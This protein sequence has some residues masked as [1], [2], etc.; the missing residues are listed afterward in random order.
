MGIY[1]RQSSWG[2]AVLQCPES[3]YINSLISL[4]F[5]CCK[6]TPLR[7]IDGSHESY[8]NYSC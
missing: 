5:R 1:F 6:T 7:L 8:S 4:D 3:A 2:I